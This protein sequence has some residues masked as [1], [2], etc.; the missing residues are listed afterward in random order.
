MNIGENQFTLKRKKN[1]LSER[2]IRKILSVERNGI[3]NKHGKV[4]KKTAE[5]IK[6]TA[7][8]RE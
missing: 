7:I 8:N 2:N 1:Q 3:L 4:V 5:Y 6:C